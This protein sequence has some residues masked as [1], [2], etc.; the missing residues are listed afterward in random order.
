MI[1]AGRLATLEFQAAHDGM[2]PARHAAV[3]KSGEKVVTDL[4]S[5]I[6]I[7]LGELRAFLEAYHSQDTV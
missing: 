1:T 5:M 4:G 3:I 7:T 6:P 2:T